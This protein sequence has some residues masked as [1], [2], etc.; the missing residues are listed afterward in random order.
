MS[1]NLYKMTTVNIIFCSLFNYVVLCAILCSVST[2]SII[3]CTVFVLLCSYSILLCSILY[4]I[5]FLF[6]PLPFPVL[7]LLYSVKFFS[8]LFIVPFLFQFCS[9]YIYF[10]FSSVLCNPVLDRVS[11]GLLLF[12]SQICWLSSISSISVGMYPMV[13]IHSPRSL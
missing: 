12:H 10:L 9:C 1:L 6:C 7:V 2:V 4:S 5:T 13:L 11:S 8:L 3:F